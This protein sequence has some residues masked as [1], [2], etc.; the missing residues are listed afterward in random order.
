MSLKHAILGFLSLAPLSGYDLKKAFDNSVRHFWYADQS[1]IYRT[2]TQI[3]DEGWAKVETIP[4]DERPNRKVYHLT[5]TGRQE[6]DT[7]LR[8]PLPPEEEHNALLVQIFFAS[9]LDN[10]DALA[11]LE[12]EAARARAALAELK[13]VAQQTPN[14]NSREQEFALLT[15]DYGIQANKFL[16]RWLERAIERLKNGEPLVPRAK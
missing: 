10:D 16:V 11:M 5:K 2:L 13:Q 14:V 8:T 4:Q 9:R 3:V 1:Q 7:W 12:R 6:L 15:L